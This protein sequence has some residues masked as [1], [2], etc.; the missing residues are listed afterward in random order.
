MFLNYSTGKLKGITL[1]ISKTN[2]MFNKAIELQYA[3]DFNNQRNLILRPEFGI[4]FFG[5]LTVNYGNKLMS[6]KI[7]RFTPNVFHIRYTRHNFKK[8]IKEKLFKLKLRLKRTK[9]DS[10]NWE[11]ISL[12]LN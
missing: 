6:S 10:S 8:K 4:T 9:N 1:G 7:L 2:T 12:K 3:T 11:S 5:T